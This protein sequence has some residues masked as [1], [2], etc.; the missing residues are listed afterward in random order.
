MNMQTDSYSTGASAGSWEGW[1]S[2]LGSLVT[3]QAEFPRG[4][5]I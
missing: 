3:N 2:I 5:G 4:E 1:S